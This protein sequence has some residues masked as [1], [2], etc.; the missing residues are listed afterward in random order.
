MNSCVSSCTFIFQPISQVFT[1][2]SDD[3]EVQPTQLSDVATDVMQ[4]FAEFP[5]VRDLGD[6]HALGKHLMGLGGDS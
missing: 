4:F 3:L 6:N 1:L 5:I 2:P